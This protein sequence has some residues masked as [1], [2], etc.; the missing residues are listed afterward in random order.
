M[1]G[2]SKQAGRRLLCGPDGFEDVYEER[3]GRRWRRRIDEPGE[4]IPIV[5]YGVFASPPP[6]PILRLPFS[7]IPGLPLEMH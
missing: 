7:A 1:I 5:G 4:Q 6:K 2:R 3:D